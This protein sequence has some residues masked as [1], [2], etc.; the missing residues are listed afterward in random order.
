MIILSLWS[1]NKQT[2]ILFIYLFLFTFLDWSGF[3]SILQ[4]IKEQWDY[5]CETSIFG[6]SHTHTH[7]QH[8]HN[9]HTQLL[10]L[11]QVLSRVNIFGKLSPFN[12][13]HR[14][15]QSK[16]LPEQTPPRANTSQSKHPPEQT[17]PRANTSQSKHLPEQTRTW[18]MNDCRS[19]AMTNDIC[20]NMSHD[21]QLMTWYRYTIKF[22]FVSALEQL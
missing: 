6:I 21:C 8:T 2:N 10:Q 4:H 1:S 18:D 17:P 13:E 12:M 20:H 11:L 22:H 19:D 15:S 9:T 3:H 5:A 14:T 16:H 7:T